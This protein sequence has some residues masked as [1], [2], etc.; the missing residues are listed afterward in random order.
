MSEVQNIAKFLKRF[1]S[2]K[3]YNIDDFLYE[4]VEIES[5][6]NETLIINVNV[7]L[8]IKGQSYAV[9]VFEYHI[10]E[11]IGEAFDFIGS[12]YEFW[13]QIFVDGMAVPQKD[14]IF[15]NRQSSEN[16]INEI[17]KELIESG[18][19]TSGGYEITFSSK[20]SWQKEPYDSDGNAILFNFNVD[21]SDFYLEGKKMVVNH[22][23][24][25][26]FASYMDSHMDLYTDTLNGI[27]I[28]VIEEEVKFMNT[29]IYVVPILKLRTIEGIPVGYAGEY[30]SSFNKDFFIE[31]S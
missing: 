13:L 11:I 5:E 31:A 3:E 8:P 16:I 19:K 1:F 30:P 27:I 28:D 7:K 6:E 18:F 9:P 14:F 22:R 26:E 4:F 23:L 15:I 24:L 10:T 25:K 29:D 17:N 20:Y 21:L 2:N 12:S